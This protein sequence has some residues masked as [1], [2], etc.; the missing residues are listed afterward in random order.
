MLKAMRIVVGHS[1]FPSSHNIV[2]FISVYPPPLSVSHDTP[3]LHSQLLVY[4]FLTNHIFVNRCSPGTCSHSN[5]EVVHPNGSLYGL[6]QRR[7]HCRLSSP[8]VQTWRLCQRHHLR[9]LQLRYHLAGVRY[10]LISGAKK[11]DADVFERDE[12]RDEALDVLT[13]VHFPQQLLQYRR[14]SIQFGLTSY[15]TS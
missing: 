9:M 4:Y 3:D 7:L 8:G 12:T 14:I 10:S 1:R 13:A 11:K 2:T 6:Q 15:C 5:G